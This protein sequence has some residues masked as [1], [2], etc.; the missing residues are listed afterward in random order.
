MA[1]NGAF[2]HLNGKLETLVYYSMERCWTSAP[3][4]WVDG[5]KEVA[6][7][8]MWFCS[9]LIEWQSSSIA[10]SSRLGQAARRKLT[11]IEGDSGESAT[12]RHKGGFSW[13]RRA[14][15]G[16]RTPGM[17]WAGVSCLEKQPNPTVDDRSR[18]TGG[19]LCVA[20]GYMQIF[21]CGS[22]S[23]QAK[24]KCGGSGSQES[25]MRSNPRILIL[26]ICTGHHAGSR[27]NAGG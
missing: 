10:V 17:I 3:S 23:M 4:A 2:Y 5:T 20:D 9:V 26:L 25:R 11:T 16:N 6:E 7:R 22:S 21:R 14:Q 27:L 13:K 15:C 1:E 8:T 24:A 18:R 12:E 19:H